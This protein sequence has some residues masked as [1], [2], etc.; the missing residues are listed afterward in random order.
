MAEQEIIREIE[1]TNKSDKVCLVKVDCQKYNIIQQDSAQAIGNSQASSNSSSKSSEYSGS[2]SASGGVYSGSASYSQ[3]NQNADSSS[4]STSN[5]KSKSGSVQKSFSEFMQAGFVQIK[6]NKTKPFAVPNNKLC[7]ITV[8]NTNINNWAVDVTK[9]SK[10]VFDGDDL[11]PVETKQKGVE[12]KEEKK[13]TPVFEIRKV[14][15]YRYQSDK[16]SGA[17]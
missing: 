4:A 8:A 5:N 9:R 2:V 14:S 7:Y 17:E 12:E 10:F 1:I 6:P 15:A 13:E 11:D 16:G 3:K